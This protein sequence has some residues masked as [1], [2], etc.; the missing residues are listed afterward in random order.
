LKSSQLR[1]LTLVFMC[2]LAIGVYGV[3][4]ETNMSLNGTESNVTIEFS[5]NNVSLNISKTANIS[6]NDSLNI[7][8]NETNSTVNDSQVDFTNQTELPDIE[9]VNE[10]NTTDLNITDP[11]INQTVP[12][13][14]DTVANSTNV[15]IEN[16]ST[17]DFGQKLKELL[18]HS[19]P[20]TKYEVIKTKEGYARIV[21][22]IDITANGKARKYMEW[23]KD[24]FS[25]EDFAKVDGVKKFVL[26]FGYKYDDTEFVEIG[27]H[28]YV[29]EVQDCYYRNRTCDLQI[30]GVR[31]GY[32]PVT[33]NEDTFDLVNT[34]S[35]EITS[36][37]FNVCDK[38]FCRPYREDYTEVEVVVR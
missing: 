19:L 22:G 31:S 6:L 37:K 18:N 34:H 38:E 7:S 20:Y 36:I 27:G 29:I 4:N 30:N 1:Y 14:N 3:L 23:H 10:T 21:N 9:P 13:V 35:L 15:T 8:L 24:E 25:K 12:E 11:E 16:N 26:R 33:K 17:V 2:A 32:L 28:K 5:I